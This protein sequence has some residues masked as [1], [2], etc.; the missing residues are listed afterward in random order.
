MV[1]T[2]TIHFFETCEKLF[3]EI[4]GQIT[5]KFPMTASFKRST[6]DELRYFGQTGI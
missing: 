3:S 2:H 1:L 4:S 6:E 5:P